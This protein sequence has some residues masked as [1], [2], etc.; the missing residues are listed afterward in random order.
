MKKNIAQVV[1]GLPVDGPFDYSVPTELREHIVVGQRVSIIFNHQKRLGYVI[2]FLERSKFSRLNPILQILDD[3]PSIDAQLLNLAKQFSAYYGCSLGEAIEISLPPQLRKITITHLEDRDLTTSLQ[4]PEE[5]LVHHLSFT[6]QWPVINDYMKKTILEDRSV[7]F[8]VPEYFL[9]EE[10]KRRLDES[11]FKHTIILDQTLTTKEELDLWQM[12]RVKSATLVIGT[13]SAIFS[14]V[15][16]LGLMVI[17]QEE[18]EAFK[19]EQSPAYHAGQV[20]LMRL[21]EEGASIL[22]TG[23]LP[24]VET[25]KRLGGPKTKKVVAYN[26]VLADVQIVDMTN[27]N[28]Q[29]TSLLSFPLQNQITK[30]LSQKQKTVI[31]FNRRGFSTMTVCNQCG[32]TLKCERCNVNLTYMYS[33]KKLVCRHCSTAYELPKVCPSCNGAYVRSIGTGLEKLESELIRLYPQAKVWLVDKETTVFKKDFDICLATQAVFRY[34]EKLDSHLY[35]VIDFD[36]MLNRS[37]FRSSARAAVLL[38]KLR[39]AAKAKL[40]IQT[41]LKDNELLKALIKNNWK[42]FYKD[43]LKI[44]QELNLPPYAEIISIHLRAA[45]EDI[46]FEQ[47]KD[48]FSK[49]QVAGI[50]NLE[51][52]EPFPEKISKLR[53]TYRYSILIKTKK[54]RQTLPAVKKVLKDFKKRSRTIIS[55]DIDP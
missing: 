34:L 2:G 41:R 24:R 47:S 39:V 15:K 51:L 32:F 9:I 1:V 8:I 23:F 44:R 31:L 27:Y 55:L 40:I 49:L 48:L 35:A 33:K 12:I 17:Y 11:L 37:D 54:I 3:A 22:W 42:N 29:K 36:S 53:G 30:A 6:E 5:I 21:K 16:K 14:P 13:R 43:E 26:Q 19:Q 25:W 7:I 28:P 20:A 4:Q 52:S 50:K 18:D 46:V 38:I 10:V 45:K